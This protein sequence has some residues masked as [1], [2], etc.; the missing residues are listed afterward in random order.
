MPNPFALPLPSLV[1]LCRRLER[2]Q[3]PVGP[4]PPPG[5]PAA[6]VDAYAL[7]MAPLRIYGRPGDVFAA[8]EFE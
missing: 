4:R 8:P 5:A 6:D 7:A 3:G 1:S 2:D